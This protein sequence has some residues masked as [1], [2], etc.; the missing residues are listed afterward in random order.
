MQIEH[1]THGAVSIVRPVGPLTRESA[2]RFRSEAG[3]V[4]RRSLGRCVVDASG[5]H[6]LD[7]M[8][9]EAL[10]DLGD[11][12]GLTG[13]ELKVC[14]LSPTVRDAL[15]LTGVASRM[16]LFDDVPSAVRSYL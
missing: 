1:S 7:S 11:E 14:G 3:S 15:R 2:E 13:R 10:L 16:E 12:L 6:Y 5:I 9:I 8:G 4:V